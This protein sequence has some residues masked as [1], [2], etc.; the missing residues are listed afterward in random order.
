M[1]ESMGNY[2]CCH[3]AAE[4]DYC[5]GAGDAEMRKNGD[6]DDDERMMYDFLI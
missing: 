4:D 5:D 6:G 3:S 2:H 1:T